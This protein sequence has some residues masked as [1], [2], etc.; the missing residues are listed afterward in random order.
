MPPVRLCHP[1]SRLLVIGGLVGPVVLAAQADPNRAARPERPTVATHAFAVAPGYLEIEAGGEWDRYHGAVRGSQVPIA[2]KY[3]LAPRLQLTIEPSFVTPPDG[4][5]GVGDLI[6]GLKVRVNDTTAHSGVIA[7]LPMIKL[8]TGSVTAR[9][10]T[11]TTDLG[12]V[13][14]LSRELGHH[15]STDINVG[16][17]WR[18]G[19]G[20]NAPRHASVWTASFDGPLGGRFDWAAEVFGYPGTKGTAGAAPTVSILVGPTFTVVPQLVLDVGSI[21]PLSGSGPQALYAGVVYNV[22]HVFGGN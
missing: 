8:P 18:S 1:W 10:G 21:V 9:T 16:F 15:V 14:I 19:D 3:G 4:S 7:L 6:F 20:S 11:G 2:L 12:L 17:T 13:A 5:A 22:G